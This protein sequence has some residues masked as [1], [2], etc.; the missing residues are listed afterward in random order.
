[1]DGRTFIADPVRK[2][3]RKPTSVDE[4]L[5]SVPPRAREVLGRIRRTIKAA[6]PSAEEVISY[7]MPSFRYKG[8]LVYYAAFED[9]LSF[10]P[11]SLSVIRTLKP[12]L[13]PFDASGGTIRFMVEHPLPVALVRKIVMMRMKENEQRWKRRRARA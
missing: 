4:Y 9:H 2:S 13:K 3:Q 8:A 1:M 10:F 11:G 5:D 7:G 6:A 12:E